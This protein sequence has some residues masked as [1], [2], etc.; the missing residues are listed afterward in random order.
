MK[1]QTFSP[2]L[3]N[4]DSFAPWA[5]RLSAAPAISGSVNWGQGRGW[6]SG[7]SLDGAGGGEKCPSPGM[8]ASPLAVW[9]AAP[10]EPSSL[11]LQLHT[12][13][14]LPRDG[15]ELRDSKPRAPAHRALI[16]L[17]HKAGWPP[18]LSP[19]TIKSC[20][21]GLFSLSCSSLSSRPL[22]QGCG[23]HSRETGMCF[24]TFLLLPWSL[25]FCVSL[26]LPS[27]LSPILCSYPVLILDY[28]G[29]G[30]EKKD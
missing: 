13:A 30:F 15:L 7:N 6:A 14:Q 16:A 8:R 27:G 19:R 10:F 22:S 9:A 25:W 29:E 26:S 17:T 20:S 4:S 18:C 28:V 12:Q 23:A 11:Q 3:I 21:H 2:S 5:F 1:M 24:L